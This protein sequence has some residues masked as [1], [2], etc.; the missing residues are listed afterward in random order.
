[1]NENGFIDE[2]IETIE[3]YKRINK[4]RFREAELEAECFME[5][6]ELILKN[7]DLIINTK[8]YSNIRVFGMY[9]GLLYT[10]RARPLTLG[11][12]VFY[13]KKNIFVYEVETE[14]CCKKLYA[15]SIVGSPLSGSTWINAF[16]PV[17]KKKQRLGKDCARFLMDYLRKAKFEYEPSPIDINKL[18][19]ILKEKEC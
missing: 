4:E 18:V 8:E 5:N 19:E 1:M 2:E 13:H 9:C 17:C 15:M 7:A 14:T 3:N 12:L 10:D 6:Y 11:E 16:C